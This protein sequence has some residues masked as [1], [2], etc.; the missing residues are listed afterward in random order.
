MKENI[1]K[2]ILSSTLPKTIAIESFIN[3]DH[4]NN[5]WKMI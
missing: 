1:E 2:H 4:S 3:F 5:L